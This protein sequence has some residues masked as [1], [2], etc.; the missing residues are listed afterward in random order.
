MADFVP[1]YPPRLQESPPGW[2]RFQMARR[3]LIGMWEEGAF[4]TD[5]SSER[6]FM[7][8]MFLCNSPESVQFAF[9]L[10]NDSFERKSAQMRHALEPLIGDGLFISDGAT[11]R[12]RRKIVAPI[13]HANRLSEFAPIMVETASETCDRWTALPEGPIDML[14]E[15]AHL[16][17]EIICRA[18]FGR[19][20]G[21]EHTT[22]IVDGF[23][24]Y[25]R[26]IGQNDLM[27]LL[28]LPDW[29]P[30][31]RHPAIRRT[32]KRIQRVIDG[33]IAD[34]RARRTAGEASVVRSLIDA[35]DERG[36]PL[37]AE[38]VRNEAA[39]LFMAGHETTANSLAWTWFLLSQTPDVEARVH[40]ELDDALGG[41]RPALA[42]LPKL[43]YLRAVFDET[44]RL[45]PPVPILPR[46]VLQDEKFGDE[47]MPKGSVVVVVPWLLHRHKKL[48]KNPDHFV[49]ERF[50][51]GSDEPVSKF[52]YVPFSIGPRVCAGMSFGLT[53][54]LLCLATLAQRFT[55]RLKPGAQ[56]RPVSRLTLRPDGGL[57]MTVHARNA[58]RTTEPV[59]AA[60]T[61]G[62]PVHRG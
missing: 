38:A 47:P 56:V 37:S 50:L 14:A 51:P 23:R 24:D 59:A 9:S 52:A 3:N 62:C 53:E 8:R 5:F 46:E 28:G 54:A 21:R 7:R 4:E 25:Q 32:T 26:L 58:A 19:E 29:L 27:S 18:I 36:E 60:A 1:P 35:R 33:I 57:P 6:V 45:Y 2:K 17:A 42:D 55:L 15:M 16:T 43:P 41:R 31:W 13:V 10:R 40:H 22:E 48:W 30:R 61:S 12:Q 11:W 20:L 49:P 34:V 39:V 44:M